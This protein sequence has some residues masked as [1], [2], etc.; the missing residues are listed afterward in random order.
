MIQIFMVPHCKTLWSQA[1]TDQPNLLFEHEFPVACVQG[2]LSGRRIRHVGAV[3]QIYLFRFFHIQVHNLC[4]AKFAH[5]NCSVDKAEHPTTGLLADPTGTPL[6][7][8]PLRHLIRVMR[9]H[10][11]SKQD[12]PLQMANYCTFGVGQLCFQQF[13]LPSLQSCFNSSLAKLQSRNPPFPVTFF[14][15]EFTSILVMSHYV[16]SSCCS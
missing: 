10:D 14:R 4:S 7:S 5:I 11:L 16:S 6:R 9:R 2:Q 12:L 1:V 15:Q 8:N 13:N 3:H